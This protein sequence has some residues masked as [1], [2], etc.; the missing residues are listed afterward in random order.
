MSEIVVSVQNLVKNFNLKI[1]RPGFTGSLRDI[2]KPQYQ[3]VQAVK[4]VSFAIKKGEIAAFIGP[5]GA[6]KS[7]TIKVLC[8]ILHATSGDIKVL[9][10]NPAL[11]RQKLAFKFGTVFGQK[12][13]LWFHLPPIDSFNL[14]GKIYELTTSEYQSRLK[15]LVDAFAI[16]HLMNVPVRKMSLGERMRCEITASLLHRPEI[17]FLD[18]PTIGLDVIAKQKIREIILELNRQEGVTF[19]LTSHDAGDV[20]TLSSRTL[21]INHGEIIFDHSTEKLRQVF[22]QKKHVEL[23]FETAVSN[24]NF[25]SAKIVSAESSCLKFE[26]EQGTAKLDQLLHYAVTNFKIKD[27]NIYNPP[28]EDIIAEIY[29]S[30]IRSG[31][32]LK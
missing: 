22:L 7:T 19:L 32:I 29:R 18:E 3:Q 1:K 9:G 17:V 2:V 8:G 5:N 12:P 26:I 23:I 25:P 24:F 27:I 4:D 30:P 10:R 14:V 15:Y 16:Q 28:L 20:E 11:E 6:G 13:Q 21:V 31:A